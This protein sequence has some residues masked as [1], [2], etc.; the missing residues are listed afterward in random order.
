MCESNTFRL[1]LTLRLLNISPDPQEYLH[2]QR[3]EV[4]PS[5]FL[6]LEKI[7]QTRPTGFSERFNVQACV[8][9]KN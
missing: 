3:T 5:F 6:F 9:E 4:H 1:Y 7:S 2:E 8:R